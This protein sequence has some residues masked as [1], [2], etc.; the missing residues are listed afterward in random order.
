MAAVAARP[1]NAWGETQSIAPTVAYV[2]T[3]GLTWGQGGKS[4]YPEAFGERCDGRGLAGKSACPEVFGDGCDGRGLAGNGCGGG[5][6][7]GG[8]GDCTPPGAGGI[9]PCCEGSPPGGAPAGAPPGGIAPAC[10]GIGGGGIAP[11]AGG[12]PTCGGAPPIA[13]PPEGIILAGPGTIAAAVFIGWDT[14][15][16]AETPGARPD[17]YHRAA[18]PVRFE[19]TQT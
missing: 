10:A 6:A 19:H 16:G 3:L 12:N 13:A 18:H 5:S 7:I 17:R 14:P 11:L 4:A 15:L 1:G 9:A 2:G 8:I